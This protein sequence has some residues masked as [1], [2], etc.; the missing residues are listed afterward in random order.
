MIVPQY[1]TIMTMV[2]VCMALLLRRLRSRTHS[3]SLLMTF[4]LLG[5]IAVGLTVCVAMP[6]AIALVL[7]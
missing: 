7:P 3:R 4:R 1:L 6:P 2:L 5:V